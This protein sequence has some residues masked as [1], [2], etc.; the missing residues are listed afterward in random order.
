MGDKGPTIQ[1]LP[2]AK[3]GHR[4]LADDGTSVAEVTVSSKQ[5]THFQ[6]FSEIYAWM[7]TESESY[8]WEKKTSCA[9]CTVCSEDPETTDAI[10][11]KNGLVQDFP[12]RV[13]E[14]ETSSITP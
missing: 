14:T 1:S 13:A 4:S 8:H 6:V 2:K 10:D 12:G 5:P 7:F 11:S 3:S 9:G